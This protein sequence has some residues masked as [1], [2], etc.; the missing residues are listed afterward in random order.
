MDAGAQVFSLSNTYLIKPNLSTTQTLGFLREKTYATNDQPFGPSNIPGGAY[1]TGSINEFGSGYFPG[2]TIINVLGNTPNAP[3]SGTLS[4]G[5]NAGAQGSNTGCI[6]EPPP[7]VLPTPSG[8]SA[9]IA[10]AFGGSYSY[11]QLQHHRQA[12]RN[13]HH[14]HGRPQPVRAGFRQ[15]RR[16]QHQL[17]RDL[18]PPGKRQSLL[19]RKPGRPVPSGQVPGNTETSPSPPVFAMTGTAVLARNTVASSTSI[20]PATTTM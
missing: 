7:A 15:P 19:S 11:T 20:P 14:R 8:L 5:P 1:G 6:P 18:V 2:V 9:S 16:F 12:R 10:L 17:R 3:E 13:G 4:I